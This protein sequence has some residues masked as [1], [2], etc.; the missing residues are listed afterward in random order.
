MV[1]E[2][3][4]VRSSGNVYADLGLED[5]QSMLLRA[6]LAM[7]ISEL[8]K[9]EGWSQ[10]EAA[11][12]M[13]TTQPRINDAVRGRIGSMSIDRLVDMLAAAGQQVE[14]RVRRAA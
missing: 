4:I 12:R 11:A 6:R 3:E 13:Q 14:I 10:R 9:A 5:P 8:I 2:K 7:A 1:D